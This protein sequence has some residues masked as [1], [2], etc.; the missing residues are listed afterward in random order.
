MVYL[1]KSKTRV[2]VGHLCLASKKRLVQA[3]TREKLLKIYSSQGG[4]LCSAAESRKALR[5][6]WCNCHLNEGMICPAYYTI[7]LLI[8]F[9]VVLSN[10]V[11]LLQ[12]LAEPFIL[13]NESKSFI[14]FLKWVLEFQCISFVP[15]ARSELED[16][17]YLWNKNESIV[18]KP[19]IE[20]S[21]LIVFLLDLQRQCKISNVWKKWCFENI[22]FWSHQHKKFHN[23]G[24]DKIFV[25][26]A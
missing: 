20:F 15:A 13:G 22:Y 14:F 12:L 5:Y 9:V 17:P 1:C 16:N 4:Y 24:W 18:C 26:K 11:W 6:Q 10:S 2:T 21:F 19:G 8:L 25:S 23:K 3:S 7:F